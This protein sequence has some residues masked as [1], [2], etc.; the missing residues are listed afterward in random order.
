MG[1][2]TTRNKPIHVVGH[3][4]MRLRPVP[5]MFSRKQYMFEC[6]CGETSENAQAT[7]EVARWDQQN[8]AIRKHI[9]NQDNNA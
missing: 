7:A 8:H 9:E 6:E 4:L 1:K 3:R 5:R 2:K